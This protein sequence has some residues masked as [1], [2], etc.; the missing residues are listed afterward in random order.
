MCVQEW[1]WPVYTFKNCRKLLA[2]TSLFLRGGGGYT[3]A[4]SL[5]LQGRI[6][7]DAQTIKQGV[8][9]GSGL[10]PVL[11]LLSTTAIEIYC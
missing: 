10:G 7:Q 2:N 1:C 8:P 4:D 3:Q 5:R 6:R 9:Q 11:F